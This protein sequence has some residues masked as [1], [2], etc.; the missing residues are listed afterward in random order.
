MGQHETLGSGL[1]PQHHT[2]HATHSASI[3]CIFYS[4]PVLA[5]Y[6]GFGA[7]LGPQTIPVHWTQSAGLLWAGCTWNMHPTLALCTTC[8]L[9]PRPGLACTVCSTGLDLMLK[10]HA[11][12]GDDP[13]GALQAVSHWSSPVRWLWGQSRSGPQ[14]CPMHWSQ[15]IEL[16][17]HRHLM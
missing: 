1:W 15:N 16:I 14:T 11:A 8:N 13:R 10:L 5:L 6:T 9:N 4:M 17:R 7:R 3:G 2:L 12:Q